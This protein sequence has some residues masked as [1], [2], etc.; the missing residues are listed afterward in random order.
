M[1]RKRIFSFVTVLSILLLGTGCHRSGAPAMVINIT[2]GLWQ[3]TATEGM[4]GMPGTQQS[5]TM[6]HCITAS[7][8]RKS[9][10]K[11]ILGMEGCKNENFVPSGNT[12][13]WQVKCTGTW[14]GSGTGSAD[15]EGDTYTSEVSV[16]II[17]DG[18]PTGQVEF[19]GRRLG[20]CQ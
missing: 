20:D 8:L 19:K 6:T 11:W 16:P 2:P 13:T 15:F 12:V 18:H 14:A 3:I 17:Y 4:K 1:D 7:D 5:K 9:A 10:D